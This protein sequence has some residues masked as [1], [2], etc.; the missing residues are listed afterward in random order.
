MS[1]P[2][3]G[4]P[5]DQVQ[6]PQGQD[7]HVQG[8]QV[9][10]I[11][12]AARRPEGFC[13]GGP[14]P[15]GA[16]G[17]P[18]LEPAADEDLC[19]LSG[20]WRILQKLRGHR[21]SLDD[22]MTAWWAVTLAEPEPVRHALDLGCGIGS[23]LMMVAWAFEQAQCVGVEA[24]QVSVELARRSIAYNGAQDRV[25]VRHGD[26]RDPA[27]ILPHE[28]FELITGTP[29]Y[30]PIGA[31]ATS[32]R[33]Q[34]GPCRVELRGGV[35]D[36]CLAASRAL[37]PSGRLVLCEGA[38]APS[39]T[40]QAAAAAGLRVVAWR[41]VIPRQGKPALFALYAMQR[42]DGEPPAPLEPVIVR[43]AQGRRTPQ[44]AQVRQRMG[45][46]P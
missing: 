27:M 1:T 19:Y 36:Y 45:M 34:R 39:R 26:L 4:Q 43:D 29:P 42:G 12:R 23:A 3:Q 5:P 14:R 38:N 37:S 17:R 40:F 11:I 18:E 41:A 31:G 13:P 7:D 32:T 44:Y 8:E 2:V 30:I 21:W 33:V 15:A 9:K 16:Q 25:S 20:D 6:D 35:E 22:L 24:Q 28:R 10:G 46:P